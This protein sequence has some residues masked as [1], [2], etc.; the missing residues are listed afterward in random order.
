MAQYH[1]FSLLTIAGKMSDM[2]NGWLCQYLEDFSP[3]ESNLVRMPYRDKA[4]DHF[5]HFYVYNRAVPLVDEYW[6]SVRESII[7]RPGW[8]LQE[9]LLSKRLLWYTLKWLFF[10]CHTDGPRTEYQEKVLVD[11]AKSDLQSHLQ[12]KASFHVDGASILDFWYHLSRSTQPAILK[13]LR[14]TG[15]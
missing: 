2:E 6:I 13:S 9:W 4:T 15:F 7:F 3:W 10:E 5:G 14:R 8:I 12:L 1:Q 11:I